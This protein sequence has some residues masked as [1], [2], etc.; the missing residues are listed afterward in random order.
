MPDP[1]HWLY[2]LQLLI[3]RK[4][5]HAATTLGIIEIM[6]AHGQSVLLNWGEDTGVWE[7]SWI[8]GDKRLT[9]LSTDFHAAVVQAA[10]KAVW[11]EREDA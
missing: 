1:S 3:A 11:P 9:G 10:R 6:R 8:S 2:E 5:C 4:S 7:C